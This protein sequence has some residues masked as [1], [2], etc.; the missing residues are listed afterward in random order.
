MV[1]TRENPLLKGVYL[2][3]ALRITGDLDCLKGAI[4]L[5]ARHP[6]LP[7]GRRRKKWPPYLTEKSVVVSVSKG[8]ERDTNLRL[9]QVIGEETGNLC[10]VVALLRPLPCGGGGH[11]H[12]HR[13]RG[14][15]P[16]TQMLPAL[17]RMPL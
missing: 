9:S 8:I 1:R 16:G 4:W 10:P 14:G 7:S 6:P 15:L 12:A 5:S 3:E 2:S 13:L 11:P 17:P